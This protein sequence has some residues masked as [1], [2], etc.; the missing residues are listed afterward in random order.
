V[1]AFT[2]TF[3]YDPRLE[4]RPFPRGGFLLVAAG[5]CGGGSYAV[6][7]R[8]FRAAGEQVFGA[9][10]AEDLYPLMNRL[11][12]AV[13]PG[14]DGLR[15]EP[16]FTGTRAQPD[17]RA[18]LS[19]ASAENLTPGHLTRALLE[20]M[21][22]S[23]VDGYEAIAKLSAPC[24]RLVG[25]GNGLR[26]NPVLAQAVAEEFGLPLVF[27]RHREEA[28]FGA[29]LLAAVGAGLYPDLPATGQL[30]RYE[31]Q[32]GGPRPSAHPTGP[33]P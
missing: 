15:C 1:T 10:P 9:R 6:L 7:E 27:P 16:Y 28:A 11:A 14:A 12:A 17:L 30:V 13:P 26:A 22:R 2:D 33:A 3:H 31:T 21:G 23:F 19:G 20:G 5:L 29:A 32:G 8:F 18:S 25:A 24:R 4:T